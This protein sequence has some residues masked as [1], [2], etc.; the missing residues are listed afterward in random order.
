MMRRKI[1]IIM[2]REKKGG[3]MVIKVG[4]KKIRMRVMENED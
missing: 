2:R 1:G 4:I 3:D